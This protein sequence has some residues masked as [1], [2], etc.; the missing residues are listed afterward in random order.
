M[1]GHPGTGK[2]SSLN[3]VLQKLKENGLE[4]HLLMFNAMTFKDVKTFMILMLQE[5]ETLLYDKEKKRLQ[6]QD[7]SDEDLATRIAKALMRLSG[8]DKNAEEVGSDSDE[9]ERKKPMI[10]V[11]DEVDQFSSFEKSFTL[12]VRQILQGPYNTNTSI[13]GI[14]NSVDLPFKKQHSAIAMRDS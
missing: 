3:L 2:T 12:L 14:A 7:Y 13:I 1:C 11:I 6:R 5:I 10:I 8:V 9:K 4:F